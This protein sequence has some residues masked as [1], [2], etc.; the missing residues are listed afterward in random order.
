M[1]SSGKMKNR[2]YFIR[3]QKGLSL[4]AVSEMYFQSFGEKLPA[5]KLS[6]IEAGDITPSLYVYLNLAEL[7]DV[8]LDFLL[9]K[10]DAPAEEVRM[11]Q[12]GFVEP[13][14]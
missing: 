14:I 1:Y 5:R 8:T 12:K 2:L 13:E 10:S 11:H 3:T 9:C 7:F 4:K 6:Q